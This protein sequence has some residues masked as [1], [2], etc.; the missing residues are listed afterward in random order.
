MSDRVG[1]LKDVFSRIAAQIQT[2]VRRCNVSLFQIQSRLFSI[3]AVS[4]N[5]LSLGFSG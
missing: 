3:S 1:N 5:P 4:L 2:V